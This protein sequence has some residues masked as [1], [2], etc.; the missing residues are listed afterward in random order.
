VGRKKRNVDVG[1]LFISFHFLCFS[2]LSFLS[3]FFNY[4][5]LLSLSFS[6]TF[7]GN[8]VACA[9]AI[10][11]IK[12]IKEENILANV[13]AR[14]KQLVDGLKALQKKYPNVIADIRGRGVMIGGRFSLFLIS[15]AHFFLSFFLFTVE[16]F[17]NVTASKITNLCGRNGMLLL[18]TGIYESIR[19]IP[20]LNV[21]KEEID[22][23]LS[24][25]E[26]AITEFL[27]SAGAASKK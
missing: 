17:P 6:G 27:A 22:I 20:P 9:A 8:A 5:F 19:F 13:E 3:S 21:T 16:F 18:T 7:A 25:F 26:K 24:I 1:H 12:A 2:F 23:G 15:I 11:T 14:G 10:A 4:F